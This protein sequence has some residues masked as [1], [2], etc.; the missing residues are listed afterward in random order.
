MKKNNDKK[1]MPC[2][3]FS[4]NRSFAYKL[5][6]KLSDLGIKSEYKDRLS[7]LLD[8]VIENTEGMV[9]VSTKSRRCKEYLE[10]YASSQAG[11][12]LSFVFFQ[13][14]NDLEF[15]SDNCFSFI[16][17]YEKVQDILPTIL[18]KSNTR[19]YITPTVSPEEIDKYLSI[20]L[21]SFRVSAKHLGYYYIKDCVQLLSCDCKDDY[22][23]I[24]D[25]YKTI[26]GKYNKLT[27]SIEK[28]IRV[29]ISK[30]YQKANDVY[31]SIFE[32][33]KV[34]NLTFINFLVEKTKNI[35]TIASTDN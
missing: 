15:N 21:K 24:K 35:S 9:F 12:N 27:S 7:Q 33:E 1:E 34:S 3:I 16:T 5:R 14:D 22:T 32:S 20:I 29:C 17:T 13:D 26:A 18:A 10:K 28:S 30:S 2:I 23:S 11:R 31:N 6:L 25:V 8:F 4:N 19:K